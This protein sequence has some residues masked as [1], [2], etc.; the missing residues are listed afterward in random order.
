M[1]IPAALPKSHTTAYAVINI[2]MLIALMASLAVPGSAPRAMYIV[3]LT[4]ICSSPLLWMQQLNGRYILLAVFMAIYYLFFGMADVLALFFPGGG[5]MESG[6]IT[7]AE[8]VVLAG[9]AS[10]LLGYHAIANLLGSRPAPAVTK[11]WSPS[12]VVIVGLAC[13]ALGTAAS[14]YWNVHVIVRRSVE[15]E[16]NLDA[17][18]TTAVMIGRAILQPLGIMMLAYALSVT[19]RKPMLLLMLGICAFQVA[20]G[21]ISDSKET[22]MRGAA[23]TVLV[24][25]LVQGKI[26]KGWLLGSALGIVLAFPIFQA[27]RY[28]ITMVRGVTNEQAASN[29]LDLIK[30]AY[31]AKDKVASGFYGSDARAQTFIE[32]ASLKGNVTLIVA[33]TGRDVSYQ[34]GYTLQ[35]L[36]TVFIPRLIW[37][38][39]P[40][41]QVGQL[42]NREFN[43][44]AQ[45]DVYI[46]PSHLGEL[47]WN[48]GWPGVIVGMA[49]VGALLGYINTRCDLSRRSSLTALLIMSV[50]IYAVCIRFEGSIATG[51]ATWLRSLGAIGLLH[52]I[53]ARTAVPASSRSA[54]LTPT[55]EHAPAFV[56]LM[57]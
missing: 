50:T 33:R 47:Y 42:M 32:R 13:W 1:T 53:F 35:P 8:A 57:R 37:P 15:L 21:F 11:D 25:F 5:G 34:M 19:R 49:L 16:N 54:P 39:K 30:I 14:W 56:N 7:A 10:A 55:P 44:S 28:E 27:Y 51:Y 31:E 2:G 17:L 46:S 12:W 45:Q 18:G 23:L 4:A 38:T 6:L 52:L 3:L 36:L 9:A 29:L 26:P 41:V 40:D 20:F 43:I 48:F 22:A 24:L